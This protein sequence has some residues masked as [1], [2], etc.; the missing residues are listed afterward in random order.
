LNYKE[1]EREYKM[2]E[3][4]S[5]IIFSGKQNVHALKVPRHCPLV[6]LVQVHFREGKALG[7]GLCYEQEILT[8]QSKS[9]DRKIWLWVPWGPEQRMT[10]LAK[11]SSNLVGTVMSKGEKLIRGFTAYDRKSD[12]NF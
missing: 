4:V 9:W 3:I 1:E 11:T 12:I 6:R 5:D 8:T 10:A 2:E 7:S